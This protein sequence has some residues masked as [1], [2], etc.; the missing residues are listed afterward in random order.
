MKKY[1]LIGYPL[2]H[3]FSKNFF[4]EKF[5][6]ENIDAEYVNFEIPSIKEL[7]SVL[8]ANPDLVGLNVTIPYKEQVI[9]YLDELDKDAAAI[10]AVNVIKIVRQKGK[11]KLIGYN[12]DVIGFTQS[13]EP[14]LEP[15]HKKS[16][17]PRNRRGLESDCLRTEKIRFGMQIRITEPA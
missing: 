8:L 16:S 13:I 3:S 4:N 11:T 15:Q 12:S 1:G 5:H 9:S 7:P 17:D 10:G 2:G 6:S 14:L